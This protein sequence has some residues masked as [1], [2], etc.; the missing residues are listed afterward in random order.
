[1]QPT[2]VTSSKKTMQWI[3]CAFFAALTAVLSQISLPLLFT[4]VPVNLA[5]FSFFFAG[6]LLRARYAALSQFI[7]LL[8]GA[9][10]LPVFAQLT[11][12]LGIL[13]G[14]TGGYIFGYILAAAI[15][16]SLIQRIHP[17]SGKAGKKKNSLFFAVS[18]SLGL[19]SCYLLGTVWFMY[20]TGTGLFLSL[21]YCVFPFIPGDILKITAA[22]FL[23]QRLFSLRSH[24]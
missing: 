23:V 22:V 17:D 18:F 2:T 7:Y 6:G 13:F 9:C 10:G 5:T 24:G 15:I 12:G 1:M 4:P 11:G 19:L 20:S 16:G 3:L 8:L 21:T 14:P